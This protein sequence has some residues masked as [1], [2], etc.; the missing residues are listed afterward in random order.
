METFEHAGKLYPGSPRV[1][2]GLGTALFA[3]ARYEEA[4]ARLCEASDLDATSE[5]PYVFM[6]KVELVAPNPLP[7]IEEKLARYVRQRPADAQ[8][9]YLYAMALLKAHGQ[10]RVDE[11]ITHL[12]EAV[13]ADPKC[14]E[15]YL[16]LGILSAPKN[17]PGAV[18]YYKKAIK[19][20]PNLGE[21]H[22]RLGVALD[23][24]GDHDAARKELELHAQIE[25]QQAEAIERERK[26]V[27]QFM[28]ALPSARTASGTAPEMR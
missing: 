28:V 13:Q 1:L 17:L 25:R 7:C 3:G 19:A 27:K 10:Q 20:D 11:A 24:M 8:A 4:A 22:Y 5:T 9:N 14:G 15:A 23:R 16:E 18:D 26:E 6:G 2:A 12:A 21:A